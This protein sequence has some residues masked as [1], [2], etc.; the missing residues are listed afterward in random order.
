[1]RRTPSRVPWVVTERASTA[2]GWRA[3]RSLQGLRHG[4]ARFL[5]ACGQLLQAQA[6]LGHRDAATTLRV[7]SL[8]GRDEGVVV[9]SPRRR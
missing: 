2:A 6:R 8:D 5:V 3:R 9:S 1:M 7:L 4:V